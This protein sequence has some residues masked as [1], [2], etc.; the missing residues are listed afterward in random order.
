MVAIDSRMDLGSP[1]IPPSV[2]N[3][4]L[5][6]LSD[7]NDVRSYL[8]ELSPGKQVVVHHV[9]SKEGEGGLTVPNRALEAMQGKKV[10][11]ER[12]WKGLNGTTRE[13]GDDSSFLPFC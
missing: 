9:F 13:F 2:V 11:L 1:F 3:T 8:L 10:P 5:I 4:R 7:G 6:S 12:M